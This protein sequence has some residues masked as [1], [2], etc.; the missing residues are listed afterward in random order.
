[1]SAETPHNDHTLLLFVLALFVFHSPLSNWWTSLN[2]PWYV[3][4]I[5]WGLLIILIALNRHRSHRTRG[6]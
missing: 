3:I 5:F 4:F 2:L 1:M 6:H